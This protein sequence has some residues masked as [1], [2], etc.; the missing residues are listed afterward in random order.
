[1]I[2]SDTSTAEQSKQKRAVKAERCLIGGGVEKQWLER[3]TQW[4]DVP[5]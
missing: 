5:R 1:M 3:F 2:R 4:I